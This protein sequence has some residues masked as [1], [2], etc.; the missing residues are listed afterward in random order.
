MNYFS[1]SIFDAHDVRALV[2][3]RDQWAL[4]SL[5]ESLEEN[6]AQVTVAAS[7]TRAGD[8]LSGGKADYL[9]VDLESFGG[10]ASTF[11]WLRWVR[12]AYPLTPIV[13][14]AGEIERNEF[15][16][17]RILLGDVSLR[18]PVTVSS[19]ELAMLQAPENNC[20]W[21]ERRENVAAAL[22]AG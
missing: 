8:A 4:G 17:H 7:L 10:A 21:Q 19:V 13:L 16:T 22:R 20:V 15:G 5:M 9:F 18:T 1:F 12:E 14:L 3:T 11:D 6:G 2:A